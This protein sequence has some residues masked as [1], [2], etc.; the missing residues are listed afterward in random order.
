[1]KITGDC[2]ECNKKVAIDIDKLEMK[3]TEPKTIEN[4]STNSPQTTVQVPKPKE[5]ETKI[6][7]V[8][9]SH[10]PAYHCKGDNC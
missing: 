4:A 9:P 6:I 2:P 10:I 1:M 5:P 3:S 7:E 8:A